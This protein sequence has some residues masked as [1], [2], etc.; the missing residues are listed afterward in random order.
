MQIYYLGRK[1]SLKIYRILAKGNDILSLNMIWEHMVETLK[2][3]QCHFHNDRSGRVLPGITMQMFWQ[4]DLIVATLKKLGGFLPGLDSE[5]QNILLV[6][7]NHS[8]WNFKWADVET[9][10]DKKEL[11]FSTPSRILTAYAKNVTL[12]WGFKWI[13]FSRI[14]DLRLKT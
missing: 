9:M 11:Y 14:Q 5:I 3:A 10:L 13:P 8:S 12:L 6:G 4:V 7:Q 2:M 1:N